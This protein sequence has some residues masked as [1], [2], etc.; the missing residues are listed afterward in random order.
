M[1]GRVESVGEE[2]IVLLGSDAAG[3]LLSLQLKPGQVTNIAPPPFAPFTPDKAL[4]EVRRPRSEARHAPPP[5]PA[6]PAR[7]ENA[8]RVCPMCKRMH[9]SEPRLVLEA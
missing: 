3:R 4:T 5:A 6:P 8:G 2:P 7:P 9:Q 1:G